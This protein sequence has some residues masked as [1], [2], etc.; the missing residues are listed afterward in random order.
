[1]AKTQRYIPALGFDSLTFFYDP[2]VRWTTREKEFKTRLVEQVGIKA[3]QNV[4]DGGCGTATLTI[5]LKQSCPQAV[6]HG[7]DGDA[8]ILSIAS[9][10][11]SREN[12]EI[13]LGQGF[14]D[15]LPYENGS[16]DCVVSSLFFHHLT[17][18]SKKQTLREIC[19]VLKP[20]GELHIADWDKPQNLPTRVASKFIEWLDGAT[21]RDSFQG[22]L[23][24]YIVTTGFVE[25]RETA[26]FNTAFGT[27]R[28]LQAKKES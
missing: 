14:S 7:L 16:F 9:G 21:T 17:P 22:L 13:F 6:V 18:E 24:N 20:S 26:Y 27:I 3:G 5:A 2:V 1:M 15:S 4:L 19:R 23:L 28:I 10:K 25:A 12:A 8:K 11:M